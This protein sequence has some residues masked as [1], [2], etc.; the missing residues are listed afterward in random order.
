MLVNRYRGEVSGVV[1][2][3]ERRVKVRPSM[4]VFPGTVMRQSSPAGRES[5]VTVYVLPPAVVA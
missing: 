2:C 3:N 4:S 1:P 5:R